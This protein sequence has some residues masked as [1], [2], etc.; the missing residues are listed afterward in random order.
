MKKTILR[1]GIH[2]SLYS[3]SQSRYYSALLLLSFL[4]SNLIETLHTKHGSSEFV[5]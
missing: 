3:S 5:I 1:I 2:I 4:T